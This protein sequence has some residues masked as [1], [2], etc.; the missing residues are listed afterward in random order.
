LI[1][2]WKAPDIEQWLEE[3]CGRTTAITSNLCIRPPLG[4]GKPITEFRSLL[5]E[6]EYTISGLCQACQDKAFGKGE[7]DEPTDYHVA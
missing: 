4:C 7:D 5:S 3:S 2:S 6:K 1:P